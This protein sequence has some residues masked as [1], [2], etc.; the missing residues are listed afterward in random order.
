MET[1]PPFIYDSLDR[2]N[3][4]QKSGE[5][6]TYRSDWRVVA[7]ICFSLLIVAVLLII[8]H[9]WAVYLIM[10]EF[11]N[12]VIVGTILLTSIYGTVILALF[13]ALG[14][15]AFYGINKA[16]QAGLVNILDHQLTLDALNRL[17]YA[18]KMFEVALER[19]NKSIYQGVSTLTLDKSIAYT[20][21]NKT[22]EEVLEETDTNQDL[23]LFETLQRDGLINRSGNSILIGF[24]ED[25]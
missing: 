14:I 18:E 8:L 25:V 7:V 19:A 4:N 15:L 24:S 6:I 9:Q 5:K 2:P 1:K 23:P 20:G 22:L 13:S 3:S 11:G 12:W 16:R 21:E 10:F 17:N